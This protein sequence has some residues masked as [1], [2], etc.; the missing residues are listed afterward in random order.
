LPHF[1]DLEIASGKDARI[2]RPYSITADLL[3]F[4]RCSRQY[5]FFA[6]RG[7]VPAQATQ[8]YFGIVIHEVLDRAHRQ[9]RGLIEGR[10][11]G[12][13]SDQD[14]KEYF[15]AVTEA[16]RA[17]GIRPYSRKAEES[18]HLYLRRFNSRYGPELYPR[19]KDTEHKLK[20]D[21][22]DFYLHGVV[23]VLA[24][25]ATDTD[26]NAMEIW[27][28][29]G[30][31]RVDE[32]SG[33][34]KN[35]RFQMQVYAELY[36]RKNGQFPARAILCFLGEDKLDDMVVEV[37][38]DAD[39][40]ARAMEVFTDTVKEIEQRRER[41]DWSPPTQMPSRETCG[42]CDIRWDCSTVKGEFPFRYP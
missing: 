8:L 6:V 42:A 40:T 13:P 15:E 21:M 22:K 28:Y 12:V 1:A 30:S 16:L 20:A 36:R 19:V 29:K 33:E 2:R 10:P 41:D 5:G 14:V 7:Y 26:P 32:R 9:Y 4:R 34:M 35:Y 37:P 27:D 25:S 23:D 18:A 38:F 3:A 11:Q 17:R 39:S 24:R 31:H